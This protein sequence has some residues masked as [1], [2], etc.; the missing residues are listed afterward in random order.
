MYVCMYTYMYDIV[1][2]VHKKLQ[3]VNL[4]VHSGDGPPEFADD[5]HRSNS[6]KDDTKANEWSPRNEPRFFQHVF[7]ADTF[8]A[9]EDKLSRRLGRTGPRSFGEAAARAF[10][11]I[12]FD[13]WRQM[14]QKHLITMFSTEG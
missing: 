13:L 11:S 4:F 2:D 14:Y 1:C 3:S 9:L 5:P 6:R 7:L 12:T 10:R 8:K